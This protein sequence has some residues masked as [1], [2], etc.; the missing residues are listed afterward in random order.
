MGEVCCCQWGCLCRLN[1]DNTCRVCTAKAKAS[2]LET[3]T[4]GRALSKATPPGHTDVWSG[5][6]EIWF[7]D[8]TGG[9]WVK[10]NPD[11]VLRVGKVYRWRDREK[12][13]TLFAALTAEKG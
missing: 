13:E 5:L 7:D 6:G 9:T 11:F 1:D 4:L 8:S 2:T 12:R 10:A 3:I